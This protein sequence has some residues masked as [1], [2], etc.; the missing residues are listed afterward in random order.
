MM[1]KRHQAII[2][3]LFLLLSVLII[4]SCASIETKPSE[5]ENQDNSTDIKTS[6]GIFFTKL[7]SEEKSVRLLIAINPDMIVVH[8]NDENLPPEYKAN[9]AKYI[10][11]VQKHIFLQSFGDNA[12]LIDRS[13]LD[14]INKELSLQLSGFISKET[15]NEIGELTGANYILTGGLDFFEDFNKAEYFEKFT[16]QIIEISTGEVKAID[17]FESYYKWDSAEERYL[18]TSSLLNGKELEIQ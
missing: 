6:A 17:I 12:V 15:S 13:N 9:R 8:S 18:K 2:K 7:I 11:S 4:L 14:T 10:E 3:I 1:L 16:R 5:I